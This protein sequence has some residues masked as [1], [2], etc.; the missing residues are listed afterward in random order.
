MVGS[1]HLSPLSVL[2]ICIHS[3]LLTA[4]N[5]LG[6]VLALDLDMLVRKK[7]FYL[8]AGNMT[9][10][11]R[12]LLPRLMSRTGSGPHIGKEKNSLPKLFSD[13]DMCTVCAHIHI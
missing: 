1:T 12:A 9:Q 3:A 8:G 2:A 4:E 5:N 10:Q 7:K 11:V 6:V 13:L